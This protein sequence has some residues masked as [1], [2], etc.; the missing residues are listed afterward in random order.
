MLPSAACQSVQR[1]TQPSVNLPI[2]RVDSMIVS[3]EEELS[4]LIDMVEQKLEL[5]DDLREMK[6]NLASRPFP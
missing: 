1:C 4:K 2:Q 5:T 3:Q 6:N